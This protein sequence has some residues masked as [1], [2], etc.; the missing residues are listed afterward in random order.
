MRTHGAPPPDGRT[1]EAPA[2]VPPFILAAAISNR[3]MEQHAAHAP[4]ISGFCGFKL[5]F[6]QRSAIARRDAPAARARILRTISASRLR[7]QSANAAECKA[8][9]TPPKCEASPAN[10]YFS[11][12][13]DTMFDRPIKT[14]K[15]FRNLIRSS[16]SPAESFLNNSRENSASPKCQSIASSKSLARRS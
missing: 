8:A 5:R 16:R 15:A 7:L 10:P 6:K 3:R 9:D 1:P 13:P 11:K 2:G 14:H 4:L 12:P